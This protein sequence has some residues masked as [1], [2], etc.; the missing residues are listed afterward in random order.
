M[1]FV[2]SKKA[3]EEDIKALSKVINKKN[4]LPILSD[5]VLEVKNTTL[6]IMA[7][8]GE[9]CVQ[10][11]V[12]LSENEGG[13]GIFCL[14]Q[15][16]ITNAL[17]QLSEQ[18]ITIEASLELGNCT[19]THSSGSFSFICESSDEYPKPHF[20]SPESTAINI[21]TEQVK[22][23]IARSIFAVAHDEL[24]P[25]MNGIHFN[26]TKYYTDVV[27]SDGH[28]LI[29]N[30]EYGVIVD[31]PASFIMPAKAAKFINTAL[32]KD[33]GQVTFQFDD[34]NCVATFDS[35]TVNFRL[36]EGRY[37]NYDSVIPKKTNHDAVVDRLS[38][39][40]GLQRV[41]PFA[42][43]SSNLIKFTF[44]DN[45][46]TLDAEDFDFSRTAT[47]RVACDFSDKQLA[48]GFKGASAIEILK[49]LTAPEVIFKIVDPSHGCIIIPNDD[50]IT[51]EEITALL[52]PMLIND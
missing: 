49:N 37:P 52:M 40:N 32:G 35:T 7:S 21:D 47:N 24:R 50:D 30:R 27:A 18:P 25:V 13:D 8:D 19:V 29:R 16:D 9:I 4:A 45:V 36:I 44:N 5:F 34:N 23:A 26:F 28:R 17:K 48:I 46:L 38:L 12:Q 22:K 14:P 33:G 3:L 39:I 15:E 1:K 42:N 10:T 11:Q 43:E 41:S 2:V 20:P 31:H 51:E 6:I